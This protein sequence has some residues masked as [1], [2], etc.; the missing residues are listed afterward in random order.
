MNEDRSIKLNDIGKQIDTIFDTFQGN[1]RNKSAIPRR[2]KV[3]IDLY[4]RIKFNLVAIAHIPNEDW[5][6]TP[7]HLLYRSI[8]TDTLEIVY[9]LSIPE[10]EAVCFIDKDNL[11]AIKYAKE[12]LNLQLEYFRE[13]APHKSTKQMP[14]ANELLSHFARC[15]PDYINKK[16][17]GRWDLKSIKDL[18]SSK[19]NY[20]GTISDIGKYFMKEDTNTGLKP[21][22]YLF[23]LYRIL[24]QTEHY[25][26]IS[27]RYSY[28]TDD[29]FEKMHIRMIHSLVYYANTLVLKKIDGEGD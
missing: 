18:H 21:I 14:S 19:S 11:T 25:S 26:E 7:L 13:Y 3:V 24:S 20:N 9:L 10:E 27:R 28:N 1:Y 23:S 22:K 6:A 15:F 8:I 17:D 16:E 5:A 29:E 12:F 2:E 4:A